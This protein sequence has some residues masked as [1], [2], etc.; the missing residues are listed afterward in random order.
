MKKTKQPLAFK[1]CPWSKYYSEK[2]LYSP[3]EA[4]IPIFQWLDEAADQFPEKIALSY[5]DFEID[6]R[7]LRKLSLNFSNGLKDMDLKRGDR[8][9]LMLPLS[10]HFAVTFFGLLKVGII[11]VPLNPQFTSNELEYYLKDLQPKLIV[12]LKNFE[13]KVKDAMSNSF[14]KVKIVTVDDLN[15][16]ENLKSKKDKNN[17]NKDIL[18]FENILSDKEEFRDEMINPKE[19]IAAILYTGG[20]TGEPKG[21][22]LSHFNICSYLISQ[23]YHFG[24]FLGKKKALLVLP[25]HHIFGLCMIISSVFRKASLLLLDK[26]N[27]E[28]VYRILKQK[29]VEAFFGVPTTYA[30]LVDYY[31]GGDKKAEQLI[32]LVFCLSGA[33]PI[34]TQLWDHVKEM[35]PNAILVEGYGLT[36]ASGGPLMDPVAK[37]YHKKIASVGIPIFNTEA[38]I[39][40]PIS[41][42][43]LSPGRQGE[44]ITRGNNVFS[45]YWGKSEL[46]KKALKKGWLYTKDI[47]KMDEDGIFF[48]EGRMDD[49]IN[50]GGEKIWPREVEKV[51]EKHV[52]IKEVA[53][54]GIK[55]DFYGEVIK[56]CIVIK[57]N[58]EA[59]EK[60]LI[61]FCRERLVSFKVPKIIEFCKQLPKSHLG[62]V[63]HYKLREM[64][65]H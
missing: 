42:K 38:K 52:K 25:P 32:H 28:I 6:F 23:T 2:M 14:L 33:S 27:P 43:V 59:S 35:A 3:E 30:A 36:E 62:K 64:K 11:A 9:I 1:R 41:G 10:I 58:Q 29:K 21:V 15:I 65:K 13:N 31:V 5:N 18:S 39:I 50:V 55:D 40:D 49:M 37:N 7:T 16:I 48:V 19:D 47:G 53:V 46:T 26:F 22:M 44:I 56:A 17:K 51:L 45:G 63:L 20:T 61:N 24:K 57:K 54:I 34:S 12:V 60:E 4:E 8:V